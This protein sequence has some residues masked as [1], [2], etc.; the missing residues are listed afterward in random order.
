MWDGA[1]SFVESVI[2]HVFS[3]IVA[4]FDGGSENGGDII[5][6]PEIEVTP[7]Y[8]DITSSVT[9]FYQRRLSILSD[10]ESKLDIDLSAPDRDYGLN[11]QS[12]KKANPDDKVEYAMEL[13]ENMNSLCDDINEFI[14]NNI[15]Y[16][17]SNQLEGLRLL[18]DIS[19]KDSGLL[20][21]AYTNGIDPL[22]LDLDGDGIET[23]SS[24]NSDGFVFENLDGRV[25]GWVSPDDGFLVLDQNKNRI[26]D[27]N[28]EL[29][30]HST[31][32]G[33]SELA[34]H[35]E[36]GDGAITI[37]DSV[38]SSLNVWRDLNSDG[39]TDSGELLSLG[40]LGI[41]GISLTVDWRAVVSGENVIFG[42][43][44]YWTEDGKRQE[45]GD[46]YLRTAGNQKGDQVANDEMLLEAEVTMSPIL[47]THENRDFI[48]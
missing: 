35:D 48:L 13:H 11:D 2:D 18:G 14:D 4:Q 7:E 42:F 39:Q 47:T 33:F 22:V 38:F 34:Q 6:L 17:S 28:S 23:L 40:D 46:V 5:N 8:N 41:A 9:D 27:D 37:D 3:I 16:M 19:G 25:V 1:T 10:L 12:F 43:S 44:E 31:Q 24:W 36:N 30:G 29:F 45:T 21:L 20:L 26:V 32:N 15:S